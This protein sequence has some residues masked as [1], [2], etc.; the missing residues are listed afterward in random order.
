MLNVVQDTKAFILENILSAQQYLTTT[1]VIEGIEAYDHE[2]NATSSLIAW[3][4]H[5]FLLNKPTQNVTNTL[6]FL[7]LLSKS[8]LNRSSAFLFQT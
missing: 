1:V 5:R 3:N 8:F 2:V 6:C 7:S 4:S